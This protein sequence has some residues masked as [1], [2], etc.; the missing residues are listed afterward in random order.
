MLLALIGLLLTVI[1]L[2]GGVW[3]VAEEIGFENLLFLL[4]SELGQMAIGFLLPLVLL[5]LVLGY[6]HIG[7]RLRRLEET[8][9]E[10]AAVRLARSGGGSPAPDDEGWLDL[11]S[12]APPG[13]AAGAAAATAAPA[14]PR[15]LHSLGGTGDPPSR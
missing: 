10:I 3:Y 1:W 13:S 6:L 5:W 4:P 12:D 9:W 15:S 14:G 2:L 7:N 8:L 11:V